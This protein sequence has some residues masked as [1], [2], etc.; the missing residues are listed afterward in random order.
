MLAFLKSIEEED[1]TFKY[2]CD[3]L[4]RKRKNCLPM[5][6]NSKRSCHIFLAK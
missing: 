4:S 6:P 2:G 3:D 1:A 5:N